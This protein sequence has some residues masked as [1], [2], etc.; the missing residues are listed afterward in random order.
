MKTLLFG[1]ILAFTSLTVFSKDRILAPDQQTADSV[2]LLTDGHQ[3]YYQKT[4]KADSVSE[5]L[6]YLRAV[7]F[8]AAKNIQQNYGYQDEGKLICTT[9]QDLNI[10]PVSVGDDGDEVQ[11]YTVQFAITLDMK[12]GSYQYTI[13]NVVLYLPTAS[14]N[15]RETLYDIYEKA[16]NL[17]SRRVAKNAKKVIDSF[18]RHVATLMD[19][20]YDSI[21][22][23]S[24]LYKSKF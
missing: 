13:Y 1:M 15:K 16:N 11:P 21:K 22:Q 17:D 8:M 7:Q 19:E 20:L 5:A 24:M 10:N 23:K 6:I 2:K 14:G 9:T 18:E 12:N 4:V 3:A